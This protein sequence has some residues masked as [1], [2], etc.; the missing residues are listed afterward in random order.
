M[1]VNTQCPGRKL[2]TTVMKAPGVQHEIE[3]SVNFFHTT[4]KSA[5]LSVSTFEID[6]TF[7]QS[8]ENVK[9]R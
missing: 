7:C 1:N 9:F 2:F 6:Q 4:E 5:N 8:G 3:L